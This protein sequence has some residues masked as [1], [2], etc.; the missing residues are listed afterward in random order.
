ML[1]LF[2]FKQTNKNNFKFV[3]IGLWS[4]SSSLNVIE[5]RV[6]EELTETG[7]LSVRTI[8][9]SLWAK[10]ETRNDTQGFYPADDVHGMDL[11]SSGKSCFPGLEQLSKNKNLI[12]FL[13]QGLSYSVAWVDLQ[14][15][16]AL[17]L[18]QPFSSALWCYDYRQFLSVPRF[19]PSL[20]RQWGKS[21]QVHEC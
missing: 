2:L 7:I 10:K 5:C 8:V 21:G 17:G 11:K 1:V 18:W 13:R 6:F 20:E 14:S 3:S 9:L 15:W 4:L 16:L 12:C 19:V